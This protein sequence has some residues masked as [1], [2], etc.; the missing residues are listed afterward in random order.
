M[1]P[2]SAGWTIRII[3]SG[4]VAVML[5]FSFPPYSNPESL[6]GVHGCQDPI[7]Q[8]P[9]KSLNEG[10]GFSHAIVGNHR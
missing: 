8:P 10:H 5:W 6:K 1:T 7:K 2:T 4:A 9:G 3:A